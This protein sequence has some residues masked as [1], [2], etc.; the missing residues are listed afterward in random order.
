MTGRKRMRKL[1]SFDTLAFV[2]GLL[3]LLIPASTI[4]QAQQPTL[5]IE[6]GTLIDG[7]GGAP[8]QDALIVIQG[9]RITNVSRRGRQ[10][11]QPRSR[12]FGPTVSSFFPV[13]GKSKMF[14]CGMSESPCSTTE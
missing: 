6:G 3:C 1:T 12:S 14:T 9:N 2:F 10:L 13:T 4:A 8:V 5:V 7:N 11:I